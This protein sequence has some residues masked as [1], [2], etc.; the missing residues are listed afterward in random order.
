MSKLT[1]TLLTV[2]VLMGPGI[3]NAQDDAKKSLELFKTLDKNSDGKLT[4]DEIA[5]D[6]AKWFDRLIR[7]GDRDKN[8]SLSTSEF[9]AALNPDANPA[10]RKPNVTDRPGTNRRQ[11][12]NSQQMLRK[13]DSNKDGKITLDELS[14]QARARMAPLFKRLGKE[15]LT[16]EEITQ[17][18]SRSRRPSAEEMMQR[19][20]ENKDGKLTLEEVPEDHRKMIAPLFNR[21]GKKSVTLKE[22]KEALASMQARSGNTPRPQTDR[23]ESDRPKTANNN[24]QATR[25]AEDN[26]AQ[27]DTN[28]DGKLTLDEA[29]ERGKRIVQTILERIGKGPKDAITKQEF[30][31][32]ALRGGGNKS[33]RPSSQSDR[34]GSGLPLFVKVL[35]SNNDGML[36]KDE[37]ARATEAFA[38]LDFNGDGRLDMLE[39]IGRNS[40]LNRPGTGRPPGQRPSGRTQRPNGAGQPNAGSPRTGAA[41]AAQ[42]APLLQRFDTNKDGKVSRDE[43]PE[44]MKARFGQMDTNNNNFVDAKEFAAA[45]DRLRNRPKN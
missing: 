41:R 29:P 35:D 31:K 45:F 8:G 42:F 3:L 13:A 1:A 2:A 18:M 36:S 22:L 25:L 5:D 40:N 12:G 33:D 11:G 23:P 10:P 9:Q 4:K 15:S 39:L 19:L 44:K 32:A 20:D 37:L 14:P 28:K 6:R 16:F 21:L 27:L 24:S 26:F 34:P 43:A 17:A 38:D 30:V 7:V